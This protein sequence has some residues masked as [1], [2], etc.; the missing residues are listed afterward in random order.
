M[1]DDEERQ[2]ERQ[3]CEYA[4]RIVDREYLNELAQ[5]DYKEVHNLVDAKVFWE[6][7]IL[8]VTKL[9]HCNLIL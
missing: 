4:M 6:K 9:R 1:E 5:L 7:I 2:L 8:Y 3:W